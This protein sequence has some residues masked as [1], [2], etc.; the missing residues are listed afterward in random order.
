MRHESRPPETAVK[1]LI[2]EDSA[3]LLKSLGLGL[4]K[5]GWA[6]D[7]AAD[8]QRALA[9]VSVNHYDVI[10]LDLMLPDISG[11][12][13]LQR[14]RAQGVDSHV[15]ILSARDR[16]DDRIEGLQRG[17][18]DYMTKPFSFEELEARLQAL[19]R[20]RLHAKS[21]LLEIGDLTLDSASR[22][23]LRAGEALNLTPSEY[24]VFE[25]LARRR[26]RVFSQG[27][28]L[29]QLRS[30]DADVSSNV[31][32]VLISSLRRKIQVPGAPPLI[33]TRRGFGYVIE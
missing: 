6:V 31:I 32:E 2:V 25:F 8:G 1:L 19:M 20:R 5:L 16:V 7:L 4:S 13:V 10:V 21:P 29:N 3:R 18:D 24:A 11:L 30:S 17:A 28:L 27:Q 23:V 15:L 22:Q 26:G 14:L 33:R 9:R 12:E